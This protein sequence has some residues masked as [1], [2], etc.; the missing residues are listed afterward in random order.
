[1]MTPAE[2]WEEGLPGTYM[3]GEYY[4]ALLC[5][6]CVS[7]PEDRAKHP[8]CVWKYYGPEPWIPEDVTCIP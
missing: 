2:A 4:P 5:L 8:G 7:F 6:H 1:M 3:N